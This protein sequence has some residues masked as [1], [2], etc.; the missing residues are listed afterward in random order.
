MIDAIRISAGDFVS[1]EQEISHF[2][3]TKPLVLFAEIIAVP[4]PIKIQF[5]DLPVLFESRR[6]I[7]NDK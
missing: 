2:A 3:S 7:E 5:T 4:F 6:F 1:N